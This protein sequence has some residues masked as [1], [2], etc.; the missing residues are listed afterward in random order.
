LR[1]EFDEAGILRRA[2]LRAPCAR[3]VLIG[4]QRATEF[5]LSTWPY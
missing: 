4:R 3:V 1:I 2:S 5:N